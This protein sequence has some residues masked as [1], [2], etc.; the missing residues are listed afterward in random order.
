M[1]LT[2]YPQA[3][4]VLEGSGGGRIVIDPGNVVAARHAL[5]DLGQLDGVLITHIHADHVDRGWIETLMASDVPVY[6]ND[7]VAQEIPGVTRVDDRTPFELVG[8]R[9]LPVDLAHCAMVNGQPGPPNTGFVIDDRLFHPG[10]G[11]RPEGVTV[12]EVVVP[13]AGPSIS[14]RDAYALVELVGARVAI[15]IH[16]DFFLA[17]PHHF[18]RSC[19]IAQIVVLEAGETVDLSSAAPGADTPDA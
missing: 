12:P 15:P 19:D 2:K 6:G 8:F 4:L 18:A 10:D 5:E 11:M 17:D 14:F 16:Y 9:V 7:H 1:L 3:C 13:I